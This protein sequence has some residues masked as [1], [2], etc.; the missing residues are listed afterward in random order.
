MN[1]LI[2]CTVGT[3]LLD[4]GK[5]I[6][7]SATLNDLRNQL[8]DHTATVAKVTSNHSSQLE[9]ATK[10]LK[11]RWD[12][13]QQKL[14]S[15]ASLAD[16]QKARQQLPAEACSLAA[17]PVRADDVVVFIYSDS[18]EGAF[19][20]ACL[21]RMLS[22]GKTAKCGCVA[23]DAEPKELVTVGGVR[24]V[25]QLNSKRPEEFSSQGIPNLVNALLQLRAAA[26]QAIEIILDVT[27]GYK[28]QSLYSAL[29]G[30][31]ADI[32]VQFLHQDSAGKA[33]TLHKLP[34]QFALL[35]W[36]ENAALLQCILDLPGDEAKPFVEELQDSAPSLYQCLELVGGQ[37]HLNPLGQVLQVRHSQQEPRIEAHTT[38]KQVLTL[39]SDTTLKKNLATRIS[40][41]HRYFWEGNKLPEA[42]DHG[43]AHTQNLL[44]L[45]TQVLIP[46]QRQGSPFLSPYELYLLINCLWLHDIGQA[47]GSLFLKQAGGKTSWEPS[48]ET[49]AIEVS[50]TNPD[51]VREAH[52]LLTY[53]RIRHDPEAFGFEEFNAEA[54]LIANICRYN[55]KRMPLAD[56][57]NK[58]FECN[59]YG[60]QVQI[61]MPLPTTLPNGLPTQDSVRPRLICAMLRVID[62]CDV[63]KSRAGDKDFQRI[64]KPLTEQD[65]RAAEQRKRELAEVVQI[66][67]K[68]PL[69]LGNGSWKETLIE[70]QNNK[71][72][73]PQQ[74]ALL[75]A[76]IA[77][78]DASDS[79]AFRG[80]Q[81][82]HFEKHDQIE[83][84]Y[85]TH[86]E[87]G[88]NHCFTV[89][90]KPIN[91][92]KMNKVQEAQ[93]DIIEDYKSAESV[94]QSA[95]LT[96]QV[97]VVN[98][99]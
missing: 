42:V 50:L 41:R 20:A 25:T 9:E 26:P 7:D 4:S 85:I 40:S 21:Q 91:N 86:E 92:A 65:R 13:L 77:Y 88:G 43:R 56:N 28:P 10:V 96:F 6:P 49:D 73:D 33:I 51:L 90:L 39:I 71:P 68:K 60:Y 57:D 82:E 97:E 18:A 44:D 75:N 74:Q 23:D 84:V 15:K 53:E 66:L 38:G 30:L 29:I 99:G 54:R 87:Q 16:T 5:E 12:G 78:W 98:D 47:G 89:H 93:K 64:R 63:Q 81:Q 17:L 3:S 76:L 31:L 46:L 59:F 32:K 72:R 58:T 94:L 36:H 11:Q 24:Q 80:R 95:K 67:S 14:S 70:L 2:L 22:E 27:G 35:E 83:R 8:K 55:R 19:A 61:T 45:A 34:I 52:N 37:Y 48:E 69:N 79:T 1:R 62:A